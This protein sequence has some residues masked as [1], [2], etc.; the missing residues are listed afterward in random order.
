V[1]K[2][3]VALLVTLALVVLVSPGII[4]RLAEKSMDK[5]LEWATTES[6]EVVVRS[7]GFDRGWFS[8]EGRHRLELRDGGLRDILLA[9]SGAE[10]TG[11]L[12]AL[13]IDTHIDHGLIPLSSM[14]REKGT[15]LPGLGSAV[16][17]VFLDTGAGAP[18]PLPGTI[19]STL[20]LGGDLR[21][22]YV[23]EP[24]T[25]TH[26]GATAEWGQVDIDVTTRPASGDIAFDG[27]IAS[28]AVRSTVDNVRIDNIVAAGEQRASGFGF[29][30]GPLKGS[31][32][33]IRFGLPATRVV[34]PI[35]IDS[36]SA[37]DDGRVS[38][39]AS[40]RMENLP[41]EDLGTGSISLRLRLVDA[42]GLALGDIKR[43]LEQVHP[44]AGS[45][46]AMLSIEADARRLVAAGLEFH[47]DEARVLLADGSLETE[48]HLAIGDTGISGFSWPGALLATGGTLDLRIAETLV[49][50]A[51]TA[52]P[53]FGGLIGMGYLRRNGDVYEL[54]AK[55]EDGLLTVN[56]AP[57]PLPFNALP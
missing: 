31:I 43:G 37:V 16:S 50:L 2:G 33:A 48:L 51:T 21:S 34:G 56:G 35:S 17:T 24:G 22:N 42:D 3:L 47:V 19:Y 6:E 12:P 11:D 36:V 4:G 40:F 29:R 14:A 27:S 1:K 38:A 23:L 18:V 20:G 52:S 53:E 9:Y 49:Q 57:L 13:I 46:L 39:R 7:E 41:L 44:D 10:A 5:Q 45:D 55:L 26:D 32:D 8:S 25:F 54:R 15:L 28:F 30:V